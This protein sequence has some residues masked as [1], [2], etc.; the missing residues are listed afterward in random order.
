[1]HGKERLI[2]L[3]LCPWFNITVSTALGIDTDALGTFAGKIARKGTLHG[4]RRCLPS[5]AG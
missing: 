4:Q 1:M 3:P 5:S 2:A